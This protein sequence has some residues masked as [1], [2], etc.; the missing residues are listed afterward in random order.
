M[1]IFVH[2][3]ALNKTSSSWGEGLY[4]KDFD[5]MNRM[6]GGMSGAFSSPISEINF[7]L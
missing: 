4:K 5:I 2:L 7:F 1:G 3:N 6:F